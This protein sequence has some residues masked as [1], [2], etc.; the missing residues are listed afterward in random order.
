MDQD[1]TILIA[2]DDLPEAD[3]G[4]DANDL[5]EDDIDFLCEAEWRQ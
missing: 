1:L 4:I 3:I 2:D 5:T